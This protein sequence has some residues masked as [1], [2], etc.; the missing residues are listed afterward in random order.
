MASVPE[1]SVIAARADA[2]LVSL[3]SALVHA[4]HALR[5]AGR[6]VREVVHE[7]RIVAEK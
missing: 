6:R 4:R 1:R 2:D 5:E 7:R 3:V